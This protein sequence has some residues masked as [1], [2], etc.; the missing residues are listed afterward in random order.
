M[1]VIHVFSTVIGE[2]NG[3]SVAVPRLCEA[4]LANRVD[5]RL[6]GLDSQPTRQRSLYL[7]TFPQ[8]LGANRLGISPEM[9]RW[10][11]DEAIS[12]RAEIMHSHGLWMLPNIYPAWAC[13]GTTCRLM[14]S[15]HGMLSG[16]AL[17]HNAVRKKIMW[18]LLQASAL[19]SAACIHATAS[20]ELDDIRR[21][22]LRQPVCVLPNGIDV[23]PTGEG[24]Q[25]GNSQL[26]FLGR[27][28]EIKGVDILLRAW[29]AVEHR[30][31][32]WDLRIAGQ[33][34]GGYLQKMQSLAEQLS[35]KRVVF[36]GALYG[37]AK[38]RAYRDASLFVLPTHSDNFGLTVGEA[39]ASGTPAIVTKG[40]PWAD[41]E[42]ERAG[43]WIDIGVDPLVACLERALAMPATRLG[44]MG[45]AGREWMLREFSWEQIAG[46]H[47]Q[48]YR[49]LLD[50]GDR[51]P[52]VR[53]D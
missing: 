51:P 37:E 8:A 41:L 44:E 36:C 31:S 22:G 40:A 45:R 19:S 49:W 42:R 9:R 43:W 25:R 5:A 7:E 28:H 20:S 27:I 30:F 11:Q 50:K 24:A 33:G 39:L 15:P 53:V 29:Q 12:G 23:P 3:L 21:V 4:M 46:Q 47:A 6:S 17:K 52:W 26:L 48:T 10:L 2:S 35:L 1:R 13:R 18:H 14:V 32:D 16:W 34:D 38:W